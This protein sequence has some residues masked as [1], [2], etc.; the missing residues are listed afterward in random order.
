MKFQDS[1]AERTSLGSRKSIKTGHQRGIM[2]GAGCL[3]DLSA[4]TSEGAKRESVAFRI[5][6]ENT[7]HLNSVLRQ[8]RI[9]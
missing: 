7:F 2:N 8:R 6:K 5:P 1:G 3:G 4:A 9:E